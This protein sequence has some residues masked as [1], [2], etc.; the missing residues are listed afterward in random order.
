MAVTATT[1]R[2]NSRGTAVR[3]MEAQLAKLGYLR[4][5]KYARDS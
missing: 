1:L 2:L 5:N 3:R 4:N